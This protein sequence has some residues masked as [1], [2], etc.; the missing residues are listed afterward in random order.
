MSAKGASSGVLA[1]R[2]AVRQALADLNPGD[3]VIVACSGGPDSL[4][5]AGVTAWVGKRQGIGVVSVV[6]DHDLQVGSADVAER[7]AGLCRDLG[8]DRTDV[9]R[10]QVAGAGGPEAAARNARYAALESVAVDVGAAAVLLGHTREDQAETV[11]LRLARGSGARSLSAM[12]A[13]SGPWRRPFL[14][15]SRADVRAVAQELLAPLGEQAWSDPHNDDPAFARVRVRL[16]LGVLTEAIGPGAV[17]G[18]ARSADLL[19]DDADALEAWAREAVGE[20]VTAAPD[21]RS[22]DCAVLAGLPRAIRTRVIRTMALT[23]GCV[24]E[25]L[26]AEHVARVEAL[27]TDWHGQGE[28]GLPGGVVAERSCGR[29][30]LRRR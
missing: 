24:A 17:S 1:A 26:A 5:L 29:L 12:R 30:C 18:L 19:R 8:V 23:M 7:A 21:E 13:R 27:I 16:L 14:G 6:V 4:A 15:L 28:V 11:L 20:A 9:V 22:A 2:S 25:D 10:V 3:V